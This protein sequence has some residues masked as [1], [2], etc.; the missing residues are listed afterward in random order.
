MDNGGQLGL[1]VQAIRD[2]LP[3]RSCAGRQTE[4]ETG[5][6]EAG[7]ANPV[8]S[9]CDVSR[10]CAMGHIFQVRGSASAG[11]REAYVLLYYYYCYCSFS[12]T[13]FPVVAAVVVVVVVVVV[14]L[15]VLLLLLLIASNPVVHFNKTFKTLSSSSNNNGHFYGA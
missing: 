8:S 10:S 6:F 2:T 13:S 15:L 14:A 3:K 11:M 1:V 7:I 4:T 9:G 5:Y 12:L